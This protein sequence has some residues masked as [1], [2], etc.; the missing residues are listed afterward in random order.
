MRFIFVS[1]LLFGLAAPVLAGDR[2]PLSG[3]VV[4]ESG[5]PVADAWVTAAPHR[6]RAAEGETPCLYAT[7]EWK[8]SQGGWC[9]SCQGDRGRPVRTDRDGR[10]EIAVDP[11]WLHHVVVA[12]AGHESRAFGPARAGEALTLRL[13]R[14]TAKRQAPDRVT[15]GSV[16]DATGRPVAGA[17]VLVLGQEGAED[18]WRPKDVDLLAVTDE[19]GHFVLTAER[20][21][22]LT[23]RV[24]APGHAPLVTRLEAPGGKFPEV[25]LE[26]G[27]AVTGRVV[28]GKT[29]LEGVELGL[30]QSDRNPAS[31][32]GDE[33]A[34]SGPDGRFTFEHVAP[35]TDYVIYGRMASLAGRGVIAARTLGVEGEGRKL[36]LGDVPVTEG[37][38]V[39]GRL[40]REG[41]ALLPA[42]T[43]VV[44]ARRYAWD[45][46]VARTDAEGRFS[47]E[48]V[49]PE[50]VT[51]HAAAPGLRPSPRNASLDR[52]DSWQLVGR[53]EPGLS[54]VR[55][56]L[57]PG[58]AL[59]KDPKWWDVPLEDRAESRTLGGVPVK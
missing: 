18:R 46:A 17:T 34:V 15:A 14:L 12:A 24:R 43:P 53:V 55:F 54:E 4:S 16:V 20:P 10:F 6:A 37:Q 56:V 25:R 5:S 32:V 31:F 23:V 1:S 52:L 28:Q 33:R 9:P 27:V 11:E 2:V 38:T 41:G 58:E 42:G 21:A 50:T 30:S 45:A 22:V 49:P 26:A 40:L 47:F 29:P 59:P 44:L 3:R 48:G 36:D 57:E 51:L 13:A 8:E 39:T 35:A 7:R 19:V